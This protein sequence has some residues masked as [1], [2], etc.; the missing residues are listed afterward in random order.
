MSHTIPYNT[1]IIDETRLNT[2]GDMWNLWEKKLL[3]GSKISDELKPVI[4]WKFNDAAVKRIKSIQ[5]IAKSL[6]GK[7]LADYI[8]VFTDAGL[9][10]NDLEL[11]MAWQTKQNLVSQITTLLK[12]MSKNLDIIEA[13]MTNDKALQND[14]KLF[15]MISNYKHYYYKVKMHYTF[16][17]THKEY[18]WSKSMYK[19]NKK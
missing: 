5:H 16:E 8:Q 7:E 15:T 9:N 10:K 17:I 6:K 12:H 13:K 1:A 4:M 11:Y 19:L 3:L 2:A 14:D 18:P